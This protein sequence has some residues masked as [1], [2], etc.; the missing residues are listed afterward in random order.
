MAVTM[1]MR[2]HESDL[3]QRAATG[4]KAIGDVESTI[5]KGKGRKIGFEKIYSLELFADSQ[6]N[7][8][9]GSPTAI[10]RAASRCMGMSAFELSRQAGSG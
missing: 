4:G 8:L 1:Q 6:V 7:R 2:E 9:S 10:F 3:W 5:S